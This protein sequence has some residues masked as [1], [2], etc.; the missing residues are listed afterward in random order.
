MA[1]RIEGIY[2]SSSKASVSDEGDYG[3][4][5]GSRLIHSPAKPLIT[6]EKLRDMLGELRHNIAADIG[7]FRKEISGVSAHLQNTELNTAAQESRLAK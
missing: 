3:A 7:R 1:S 2:N 5:A 4:P 6:E